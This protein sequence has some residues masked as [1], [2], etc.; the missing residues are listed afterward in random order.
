MIYGRDYLNKID[1]N[2][3][4]KRI[5]NLGEIKVI[6]K[7]VEYDIPIYTPFGD[8]EKVDLVAEFNGKLQK[9]QVK[10][11]VKA[12]NGVMKFDLVSSTAH[13]K[14]GVRHKYTKNEIDYFACYNIARDKIFLIPIEMA[15]SSA[16]TIRFEEPK[17]NQVKNIIVEDKFLIENILKQ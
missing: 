8:C 12:E 7:F 15:P 3:L 11:S 4:S 2:S 1:E 17:N 10:T 6:S 16:I 5:G 14:N 9:I 13:R